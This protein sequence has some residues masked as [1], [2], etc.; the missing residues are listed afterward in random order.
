[1]SLLS[2]FGRRI[3]SG[4]AARVLVNF[5]IKRFKL[6]PAVANMISVVLMEAIARQAEKSMSG[7]GAGG[8]KPSYGKKPFLGKR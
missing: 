4:A 1:M 2:F 3:L 5:L 6:S 8:R 7:S